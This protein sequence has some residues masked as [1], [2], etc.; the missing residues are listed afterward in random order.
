MSIIL[1]IITIIIN[2]TIIITCNFWPLQLTSCHLSK[3][4]AKSTSDEQ[5]K[6][7]CV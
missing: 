2:I 3:M 6:Y 7:L 1:I 4:A 5:L